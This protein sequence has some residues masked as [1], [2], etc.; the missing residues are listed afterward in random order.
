[1]RY[2]LAF[3][4]LFLP[5][6]SY[7]ATAITINN[8]VPGDS[9]VFQRKSASNPVQDYALS[10]TYTGT[11][12]TAMDCKI[13]I[14]GGGTA[15]ATTAMTGLIATG[16]N[17]SATCPSVPQGSWYNAYAQDHNATSANATQTQQSCVGLRVFMMG[18][19]NLDNLVLQGNAPQPPV[20]SATKVWLAATSYAGHTLYIW[21]VPFGNGV[22]R[23]LNSVQS[24][25]GGTTCVGAIGALAD[26][27]GLPFFAGGSSF[28]TS[29]ILP[30]MPDNSDAEVM[31]M[32]VGGIPVDGINASPRPNSYF[33]ADFASITDSF[34]SMTGR[35]SVNSYVGNSITHS[36]NSGPVNEISSTQVYTNQQIYA[37]TA[38]RDHFFSENG[39]DLLTS[40]GNHFDKAGLEHM[41]YR[42]AQ[43]ILYNLGLTPQSNTGPVIEKFTRDGAI[44]T[45]TT[46]QPTGT[47][48]AFSVNPS[49]V[50]FGFYISTSNSCDVPANSPLTVTSG[51][52]NNANHFTLTLSVDPGAPVYVCYLWGVSSSTNVSNNVLFGTPNVLGDTLGTPALMSGETPIAESIVPPGPG[53]VRMF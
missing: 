16:G 31:V 7:A 2:F 52:I 9:S 47:G 35:N 3:L 40:D 34:H 30:N 15:L 25:L 5:F 27:Q 45:F 8:P 23:M 41:G 24:T 20:N 46:Y 6:E 28:W 4:L 37:L 22:R 53:R 42:L 49:G 21:D 12:P 39:L 32:D 43:G 48:L 36:G 19:S 1:M 18:T 29:S 51:A 38:G 10:G 44:L 11:A 17:W 14:V 26:G 13:N 33:P 50:P